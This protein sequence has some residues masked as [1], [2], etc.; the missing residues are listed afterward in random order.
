MFAAE[1]E[2]IPKSLQTT[3]LRDQR[4]ILRDKIQNWETVR[5][6]YMPGALQIQTDSGL[7]PTALWNSN[8]NPEDVELW[9]PSAISA[10]RRR[11]ACMEGLPE[12]E[13][14]FRTAQCENSLDGLRRTLRVKTRMVYFKNKNIRG[15]REGTRSRAIIDRVHSR[16]V[17]HVQKYRAARRAKLSLEGPGV[18]ENT[19]QELRN[20]DVRGFASGLKKTKPLRKG[21]WE[22]GH[23]PPE[24]EPADILEEEVE[25]DPDLNDGTEGGPVR[26][27]KKKKREG[28]GETRKELSWIW[29]TLPLSDGDDNDSNDILRAEW[30]R[31]RARVRR[32]TEEVM[33]L[34]EE[35]RRVLEF[36]KWKAA[37]WD[38]RIIGR[39]DV[40]MELREGIRAYAI[41]QAQLQRSLSTSFK[42]L[43]KTP[44]DEIEGLIH[45][46]TI[47]PVVDQPDNEE[48]EDD[49][50]P[51]G[52]DIADI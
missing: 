51:P 47:E 8:P 42:V 48:G 4:K 12:M 19:Y 6:V 52:L 24:A 41:E 31:S 38:S 32:S 26:T 43:W 11:A 34:L 27:K 37:Q 1:Q 28:T 2:N 14:K 18:W 23:G 45:E 22:D 49:E 50:D 46:E 15:Q 39:A 9:L 20:E 16:A 35:M 25:S 29:R 30:A 36:L 33:L 40:G 5:L 17:R 13:L 7:N 3:A 21:I 10:N 44:L